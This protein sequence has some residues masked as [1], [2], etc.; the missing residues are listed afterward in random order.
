MEAGGGLVDQKFTGDVCTKK[1]FDL[2]LGVGTITWEGIACPLAK[3][4]TN[5]KMTVE[6]SEDLPSMIAEAT[7]TTKATDAKG[8]QLLCLEVKTTP[9]EVGLKNK[10]TWTFG[11]RCVSGMHMHF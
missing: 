1:S 6:L 11:R 4:S 10:G 2:P 5:V 3:G 9:T 8:D 7:I